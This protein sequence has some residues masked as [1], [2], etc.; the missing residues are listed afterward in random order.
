MRVTHLFLGLFGLGAGL[1][2]CGGGSGST[3]DAPAPS[4]DAFVCA[5]MGTVTS[6]GPVA[7]S[8]EAQGSVPAGQKMQLEVDA[9]VTLGNP[10]TVGFVIF[11]INNAGVFGAAAGKAGRFETPPVLGSYPMDAG[12]NLGFGIEFVNGVTVSS[13]GVDIKPTQ[14]QLLDPAA[15][16]TVRLDMWA[17]AATP[18]GTTTIGATVT[19]AT[20][21][22]FNIMAN[23]ALAENGCNMTIQNFQF[24]GLNVKWQME[25]FPTAVAPALTSQSQSQ[26]H[27]RPWT[28][29][30]MAVSQMN[31]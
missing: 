23:G 13:S 21:K 4:A 9:L 17:P 6:T 8:G 2:A 14:V 1:T 18:G 31:Q 22:G 24:T 29:A 30:G 15:G 11:Q 28:Q 3:I 10:P 27:F 25:A 5:Q 19:N 20:F 26:L 7:F 12:M 16:G